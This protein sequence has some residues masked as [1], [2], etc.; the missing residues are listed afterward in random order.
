MIIAQ[1][2]PLDE[3]RQM[4]AGHRRLLVLGCGTCVTVCFAGGEKEVGL[5]ATALRAALG[6]DVSVEEAIVQRQCEWEFLDQARDAVES[7]DAVISL[8]CGIGVQGVAERYPSKVVVPG[9]NTSFLGLTEAPG[10]WAERCMACGDCMLDMTGGICPIA[11]CAK[12]LMNGPCGGAQ[13]R[14]CEISPDNPCAWVLIHERLT[15]LGRQDLLEEIIPARDWRTS[16]AGGPRRVSR[17]DLQVPPEKG[18]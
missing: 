18:G 7:A 9:L 4:V 3:I 15:A 6:P 11:R 5:M 1:Q 16:H 2:K 14:H 12:S 8:G 17:P 13:D 10:V